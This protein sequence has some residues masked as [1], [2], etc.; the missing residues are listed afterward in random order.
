MM[1]EQNAVAIQHGE[2]VN[3][4]V[5]VKNIIRRSVRA[6]GT[7]VFGIHYECGGWI[8][9]VEEMSGQY[10]YECGFCGSNI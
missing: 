6:E 3:V 8:G 10:D 1:A 9:P 2:Q 5:Q 7:A 4:A